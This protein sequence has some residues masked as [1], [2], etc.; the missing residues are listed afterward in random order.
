M[1]LAVPPGNVP[2]LQRICDEEHVELADL[3]HFGTADRELIL[4]YDGVEVGRLPMDFLHEGIPTPTRVATWGRRFTTEVTEG[5]REEKNR[6]TEE[7]EC[8]SESDI[9]DTA[10]V[11]ESQSSSLCNSVSSVVSSGSVHDTLLALLAHPDVASKHW[12]VSQYDHEVQGVTVVKPLVGAGDTGGPGDAAV[13]E[14]VP[15]TGRGLAIASGLQTR[16]GDAERGGGGGD[17]YLLALP[18][19]DEFVRIIVFVGADPY[20]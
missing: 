13:I 19:I 7:N 20:L 16:V 1:V 17:P 8:E 10:H 5:H 9:G 15:G 18:G 4:R 12:I 3:G 6:N 11:S 14:P 2:A